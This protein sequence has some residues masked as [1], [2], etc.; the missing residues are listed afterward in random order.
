MLA[1]IWQRIKGSVLWILAAVVGILMFLYGRPQGATGGMPNR[2][3]RRSLE[4]S[5]RR[6]QEQLKAKAEL[7][8]RFE[9]TK[10]RVK[11]WRERVR[12][13]GLMC[14]TLLVILSMGGPFARA[15][16]PIPAD[17]DGLKARY[18]EAM[19]IIAKQA[20][21]IREADQLIAEL[22][23]ECEGY[24]AQLAQ[25]LED[26]RRLEDELE[27][28]I[29]MN[30]QLHAIILRLTGLRP[31]VGLELRRDYSGRLEFAVVAAV[32]MPLGGLGTRLSLPSL[33]PSL[34]QRE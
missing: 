34:A 20:A 6:T 21:A 5:R 7:D 28:Y 26:K 1:S 16:D 14:L 13:G 27:G 33:V 30:E 15:E 22:V 9:D 25:A 24:K 2:A 11:D 31:E 12:K 19:E 17:Y 10:Q 23:D 29:M 3:A 18:L 32:T 4:E 8:E